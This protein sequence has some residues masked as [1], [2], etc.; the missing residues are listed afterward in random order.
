MKG[1]LPH[2]SYRLFWSKED[3]EYVAECDE[4]PGLTGLASAEAQA[5]R[6]L[7][8]AIGVWLVHL[9]SEGRPLPTPRWR[10]S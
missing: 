5:V 1:K 4:I 6:E 9:K 2:Y 10:S 3:L 7:K 8:I